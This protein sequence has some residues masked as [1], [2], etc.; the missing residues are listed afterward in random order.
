MDWL[1]YSGGTGL[2]GEQ[3]CRFPIYDRRS[4]DRWITFAGARTVP[5]FHKF[6]SSGFPLSEKQV[7][8]VV[9]NIETQSES[10]EAMERVAA[11]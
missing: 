3:D 6:V 2:A 10:M 9:E 5:E 1:L 11:L 7:P 4:R 8:Q